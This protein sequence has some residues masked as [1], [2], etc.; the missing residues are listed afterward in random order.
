MRR[1]SIQPPGRGTVED[2]DRRPPTATTAAFRNGAGAGA[3]I[4][5]TRAGAGGRI[6]ALPPARGAL[7]RSATAE[8]G[9]RAG[10]CKVMRVLVR[11]SDGAAGRVWCS[12]GSAAALRTPLAVGGQ[13]R[14]C[15]DA[16][17]Q[18]PQHGTYVRRAAHQPLWAARGER[19]AGGATLAFDMGMWRA[20]ADAPRGN[21]SPASAYRPRSMSIPIRSVYDPWDPWQ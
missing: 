1:P 18:D 16:A 9:A 14:L 19:C 6:P 21:A 5:G 7:Y 11:S 15:R 8:G 10:H 2:D 17:R 13:L 12:T 3:A 4:R 20:G